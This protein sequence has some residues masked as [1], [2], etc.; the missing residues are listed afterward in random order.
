MLSSHT[1]RG[2][3]LR[4]GRNSQQG[5]IYLITTVLQNRHPLFNDHSLARFLVHELRAAH[6][7]NWVASLAWVIMPD[8][9]H[10]LLQL[11]K[12]SL[13][14][15]VRRIKNNSARQINRRIGSGGSI[16]QKGYHDRAL[17]HEDDLVTVA[18]L[19]LPIHCAPAW[20]AALVI[21]RYGMQPGFDVL[22]PQNRACIADE[23]APTNATRYAHPV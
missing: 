12:R 3:R 4:L 22:N 16:W 10:W 13:P 18:R 9:L 20:S 1:P 21:I 15:V 8:H 14:E 19:W 2:H 17:R 23:S 5:Q 6:E 7:H 11:E